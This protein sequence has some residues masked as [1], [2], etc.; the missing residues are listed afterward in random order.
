MARLFSCSACGRVHSKDYICGVKKKR[1]A[2][3]KAGRIDESIY[4]S[5]KWNKARSKVLED[6]NYVCLW[7]WYKDGKVVKADCVHH[8]VE[9]RN[10]DRLAYSEDNLIALSNDK[11]RLVHELYKEDIYKV[12]RELREMKARWLSGDRF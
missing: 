10:D 5:G 9:I 6:C 1:R 8:I 7:S 11:H 4:S 12:Q 3:I 2:F